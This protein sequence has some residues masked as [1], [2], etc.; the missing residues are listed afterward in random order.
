MRPKSKFGAVYCTICT[1]RRFIPQLICVS[2][3]VESKFQNDNFFLKKLNMFNQFYR[4]HGIFRISKFVLLRS[5]VVTKLRDI[6]VIQ[7]AVFILPERKFKTSNK[8]HRSNQPSL[9]LL[10]TH[11]EVKSKIICIK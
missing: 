1:G 7:R 5:S 11:R 8:F 9:L 10:S 6:R 3:N 2:S 4:Y